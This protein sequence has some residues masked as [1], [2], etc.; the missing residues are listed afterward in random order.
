MDHPPVPQFPAG[1]CWG[2]SMSA[3]QIEGAV[4]EDGWYSDLIATQ[5]AP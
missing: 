2:V 4:R 1:F 5:R 3:Y